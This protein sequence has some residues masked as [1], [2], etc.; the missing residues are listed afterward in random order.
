MWECLDSVLNQTLDQIEV[1][2]IDDGS[3]DFSHE[4]LEQYAG[5]DSRVKLFSQKNCG[6]GVAR[7]RGIEE[8]NGKYLFFMDADDFIDADLLKDAHERAESVDADI[9]LFPIDTYDQITHL[10]LSLIHILS[11]QISG[12]CAGVHHSRNA[13]SN[14]WDAERFPA[15]LGTGVIDSGAGGDATG[16]ELDGTSQAA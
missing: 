15:E 16:T 11:K 2:C 12:K 1:I 14:D 13:N 6:V 3:T 8:E 10:R 4:I 5:Q 7:N 9:V